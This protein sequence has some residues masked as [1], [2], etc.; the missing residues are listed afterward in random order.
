MRKYARQK[1]DVYKYTLAN[2]N[3]RENNTATSKVLAVIPLG[4]MVQ[5][6]DAAEDWYEVIYNNLKGYVYD[7]FLS[8]TKYTWRDTLLRSYPS[9]E[10]NPVT[11]IPAKA[12]VQVLSVTGDWSQVIYNN[13]KGYIFTPFLSDDANPPTEY[14]FTYFYTDMTRFVNDNQI[15]SPTTNLITTDLENKLTYIFVQD[16]NNLWKQ[17][18]KWECTVGKPSTPT[19]KGTFYVTGRKPYFGTDAYRVKYATRIK[20]AYYYHSI[21]FNAEG[22]EVI[23]DRL[24]MALSHGCIRLATENAQWIYD[25]ILDATAIV[26]N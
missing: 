6:I 5:V 12:E 4:S 25:N 10:S 24:G 11:V 15:K 16:D 8:I 19:I 1:L 14:D 20:G 26:I 13:R 23:D 2:V 21:L 9:A 17:L 18:Y 22:T 7:A 3:L